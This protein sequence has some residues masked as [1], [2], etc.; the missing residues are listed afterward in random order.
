MFVSATSRS[1]ANLEF[2]DAC[3]R[4]S[5]LEYSKV[6]I[7]V[8]NNSNHLTLSQVISDSD[9]F[10][11]KYRDKTRLTPIAFYLEQDISPDDLKLLCKTC[12]VLRVG[13]ITIPASQLG[14]PFNTEIDRLR[15][16]TSIA[17][18]N[19]ISLSIK[20]QTG[21]LTED[22]HTAVELCQSVQ[23][24]GITLD[25]SYYLCGP[26]SHESIDQIYPHVYHTHLRDTSK[27]Q[28]QVSTGLG[29]MDYNHMISQLERENYKQNLSVDL[30]PEFTDAESQPLE[31]RKLR[32]LLES[33]L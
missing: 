29:E 2:F 11:H 15:E 7:W 19:G 33:L 1:F 27:D 10:A 22:P 13:Q 32:M 3:Q 28:L 16:L 18:S 25:P 4:I 20:T 12:K 30:L 26:H 23:G 21:T 14:T 17:S 24:L 31:M 9:A 8:D 5:D 6:E